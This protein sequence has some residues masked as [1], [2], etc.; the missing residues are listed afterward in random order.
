MHADV[1]IRNRGE[2]RGSGGRVSRAVRGALLGAALALASA[3]T[4]G[5]AAEIEVKSDLAYAGGGNPR[6]T[7][8][9]FLPKTR[10]VGGRL[11]VVIHIHGGGWHSGSKAAGRAWLRPLVESGDFAGVAINYRLSGEAAWPAALHDAKA[12]VRWVRAQAAEHGFDPAHI[13]VAGGSAGSTLAL[14]LGFTAGLPECDGEVGPHRGVGT[15][16]ACVVNQFGRIDFLAEP[17]AA[18]AG[19]GQLAGLAERMAKLFGGSEAERRDLMRAASPLTYVGRAAVPVLTLHGA[20]DETVPPVQAQR[21]HAAMR[22][23][24]KAHWLIPVEGAGHGFDEA[25]ATAR[26]RRFLSAQLR[27]DGTAEPDPTPIVAAK[28]RRAAKQ[29][30]TSP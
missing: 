29:A 7:L 17:A 26:V 2:M 16:V 8:D 21:L 6:Q 28:P 9:V 12:A 24:G 3:P 15:E 11:P 20:L 13:G 22:A 14:L 1:V 10:P 23:A 25:E 5:E 19:P 27:G 4:R 30:K 18:R